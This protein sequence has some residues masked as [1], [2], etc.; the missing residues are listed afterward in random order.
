MVKYDADTQG[1]NTVA[2]GY[3]AVLTYETRG[4]DLYATAVSPRLARLPEGVSEIKTA[5]LE[6]LIFSGEPL[7]L[8]DSRPPARYAQ[9]HLPGAHSLP[10][11]LLNEKQGE[12]LPED[13]D[14]PLVF[15]CGGVT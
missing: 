3:A 10:V 15:Y 13:K 11:P 4:A 14:I 2:Q 9:S 7:F 1:I 5:E 8:A 12:V 6:E